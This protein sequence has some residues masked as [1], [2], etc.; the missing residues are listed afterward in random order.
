[1]AE[2]LWKDQRLLEQNRR[3]YDHILR[4][5]RIRYDLATTIM[6]SVNKITQETRTCCVDLSTDCD[7]AWL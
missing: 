5:L 2:G 6:S 1:M 4:R 7:H 3:V